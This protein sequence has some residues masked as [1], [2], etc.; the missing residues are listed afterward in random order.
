[1]SDGISDHGI[2]NYKIASVGEV[3]YDNHID[4]SEVPEPE[5]EEWSEED[6]FPEPGESI[7]TENL[8]EVEEYVEEVLPGGRSSNQALAASSAG[9]NTFFYGKSSREPG[10]EHENLDYDIDVVPNAESDVYIFVSDD[11]EKRI[12]CHK[13]QELADADYAERLLKDGS[14]DQ[15][16]YLMVSNGENQNFLHSLFEGLEETDTE[17]VFDPAPVEGSGDFLDYECISYVTPNENEYVQ[18]ADEA[19]EFDLTVLKTSADGVDID[20]DYFVESPDVEPVDTTGAGDVF[21]GYLTAS[22]SEGCGLEEAVKRATCAAS[23]SVTREGAQRSIPSFD[24][25][26]DY[27]E[28]ELG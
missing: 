19:E 7:M 17:V 25:V 21:N 6:W 9:S 15:T 23:L 18:I 5:L 27:I 4:L 13:E 26:N 1:M 3:L 20:G 2:S 16:D 24:Q 12:A 11:G 28:G 10:L 22:L 14:F 8:P